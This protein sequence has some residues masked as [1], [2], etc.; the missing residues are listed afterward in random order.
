MGTLE[1]RFFSGMNKQTL[2]RRNDEDAFKI[3]AV[4]KKAIKKGGF[5]LRG[6]TL[7]NYTFNLDRIY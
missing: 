1:E 3:N 2:I 7:A 6:G 4:L 5:I